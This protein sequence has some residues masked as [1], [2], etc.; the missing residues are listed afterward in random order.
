M[1]GEYYPMYIYI[2]INYI[3]LNASTYASTQ[4]AAVKMALFFKIT[5]PQVCTQPLTTFLLNE[6]WYGIS[7]IS[8]SYPFTI[9]DDVT[10]ASFDVIDDVVKLRPTVKRNITLIIWRSS[11]MLEQR[12]KKYN[13]I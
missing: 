5:A 11:N 3:M 1:L 9:L 10:A 12:W 6:A 4:W 13:N 7:V 2:L 8:T